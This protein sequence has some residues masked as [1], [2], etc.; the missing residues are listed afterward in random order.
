LTNNDYVGGIFRFKWKTPYWPFGTEFRG[1]LLTKEEKKS[2]F[3][4]YY[5]HKYWGFGKSFYHFYD[6]KNELSWTYNTFKCGWSR[7]APGTLVDKYGQIVLQTTQCKYNKQK[8]TLPR[9]SIDNP[10]KNSF[11][12]T[13]DLF[14]VNTQNNSYKLCYQLDSFFINFI[15]ECSRVLTLRD[16]QNNIILNAFPASNGYCSEFSLEQTNVDL[17]CL[18][19]MFYLYSI[20][21][22]LMQK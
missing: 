14:Y 17:W 16:Q 9:K 7:G 8:I 1:K 5:T 2:I 21:S 12:H 15:D 19:P 3:H 11:R 13:F 22:R 10:R 18:I 20:E 6:G 4:L